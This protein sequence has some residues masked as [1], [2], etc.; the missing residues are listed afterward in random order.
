MQNL[1]HGMKPMKGCKVFYKG[2]M[3]KFQKCKTFS[4]GLVV[5]WTVLRKKK[6][7][8]TMLTSVGLGN[9][10]W[11][12]FGWGFKEMLGSTPMLLI[13]DPD[14]KAYFQKVRLNGYSSLDVEPLSK[15]R[16][17]AFVTKTYVAAL[18]T[19][20]IRSKR[21]QKKLPVIWAWGE[22]VG[23]KPNSI[24]YHQDRGAERILL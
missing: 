11:V 15:F 7:I 16:S 21:L 3:H 2:S 5:H 22:A 12:G 14:G 13:T 8:K 4:D 20:K 1:T 19:E 24:V 18:W 9:R 17:R 23:D 10:S 6:K